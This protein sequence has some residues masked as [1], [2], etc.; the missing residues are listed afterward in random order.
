MTAVD[1]LA[2]DILMDD[3]HELA[4]WYRSTKEMCDLPPHSGLGERSATQHPTT[5]NLC[6]SHRCSRQRLLLRF[7]S[8]FYELKLHLPLAA[9]QRA[10]CTKTCDRAQGRVLYYGAAYTVNE[11]KLR[12]LR[13][14]LPLAARRRA[15][16]RGTC[17]CRT[18][19]SAPGCGAR[20]CCPREGCGTSPQTPE[21]RSIETRLRVKAAVNETGA[22]VA[23]PRS[24]V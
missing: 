17:G 15:P 13:L 24:G 12:V 22:A 3:T 6:G 4:N 19:P 9:P 16:C 14:H 10:P 11:W 1:V 21:E 7:Q 23:I 18:G 5:T 2:G 8:R 20:P